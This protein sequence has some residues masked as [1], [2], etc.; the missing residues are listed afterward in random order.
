MAKRLVLNYYIY[1][2]FV[3]LYSCY[4]LFG[5]ILELHNPSVF[6]YVLAAGFLLGL[7]ASLSGIV[8]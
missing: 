8:L 5:M 6:F 3:Y 1:L 7:A 4:S 2:L